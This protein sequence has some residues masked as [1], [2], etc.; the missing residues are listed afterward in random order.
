[1]QAATQ[2]PRPPAS[3]PPPGTGA[4]WL[5][6]AVGM[7]V[8]CLLGLVPLLFLDTESHHK[9]GASARSSDGADGGS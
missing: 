3:P 7:G 8:G 4:K 5:G 2:R 1:M 9:K 6:C